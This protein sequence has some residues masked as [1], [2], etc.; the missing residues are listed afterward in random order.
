MQNTVA[1]V[2]QV[3]SPLTSRKRLIGGRY[4]FNIARAALVVREFSELC[5]VSV[6]QARSW[7]LLSASCVDVIS[8]YYGIPNEL[9]PYAG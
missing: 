9:L 7:S 6:D 3:I 4:P 8:M 2:L 1:D 5:T